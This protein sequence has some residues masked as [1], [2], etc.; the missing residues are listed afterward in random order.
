MYQTEDDDYYNSVDLNHIFQHNDILEEWTREA[1]ESLLPEAHMDNVPN[2][3][4]DDAS[5]RLSRWSIQRSSKGKDDDNDDDEDDDG[6]ED[7]D[8]DGDGN[9]P[10]ETQQGHGMTWSQGDKNY[11]ATQDIN[12]GYC[13]RIENQ[14][15]FIFNLTDYPSQCDDSQS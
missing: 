9:V 11:Y 4:D 10:K 15:R 13:P 7:D 12:H 8:N 14:R 3:E 1:E 5:L 2:N 6:D